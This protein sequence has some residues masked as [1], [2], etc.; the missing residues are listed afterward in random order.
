MCQSFLLVGGTCGRVA[1]FS[2]RDRDCFE[3]RLHGRF[4]GADGVVVETFDDVDVVFPGLGGRRGGAAADAWEANA[5]IASAAAGGTVTRIDIAPSSGPVPLARRGP[6]GTGAAKPVTLEVLVGEE[7][8][9]ALLIESEGVFQ[10]RLPEVPP[11]APPTPSVQRRGR[12]GRRTLRFRIGDAAPVSPAGTRG[13]LGDFVELVGDAI[14]DQVRV[15]VLRFVARAAVTTLRDYLERDLVEGLVDMTR[16][17]PG[18]WKPAPARLAPNWPPDRPGCL[19]LMIHGTFSTTLGSFGAL[20]ATDGGKN[21]LAG[22]GQRYDAILGYDHSTLIADPE[23]NAEAIALALDE[24]EAPTGTTVD[25]VAYS[26]GGLVARTLAEGLM[27]KRLPRLKIGRVA[28]VGCTNGGTALAEPENWKALIDLTTNLAAVAGR[29]LNFSGQPLAGTILRESVKTIGGLVQAIVDE[30]LDRDEVAGLAAMRPNSALIARLDAPATESANPPSYYA[31]GSHF[32]PKL[33][34]A[35]GGVEPPRGI[36]TKLALTLANFAANGIMNEAN[37]L[38]VDN[39]AVKRFGAH[40]GRLK[41]TELWSDNIVVFH[42]NYFQQAEI[43]QA[44]HGFLLVD[45]PSAAPIAKANLPVFKAEDG[46]ASALTRRAEIETSP[47]VVIERAM[48]SETRFY[49]RVA[50]AVLTMIDKAAPEAS[51]LN[52]LD[53]HEPDATPSGEALPETVAAEG[54]VLTSQGVLV[55]VV[56]PLGAVSPRPIG[57]A[58]AGLGGVARPG[59][60]PARGRRGR[61][62]T[63]SH[64]GGRDSELVA[65]QRSAPDVSQPLGAALVGIDCHFM[66]EMAPAPALGR[67]APLSVTISR[68]SLAPAAGTLSAQDHAVVAPEAR[69][70]IEVT[71]AANC[72][73]VAEAKIEAG[74]P[75]VGRPDVYD[76]TI[77]GLA[78]G[79]GEI[80]VDVR[81]GVRRLARLVLQPTFVATERLQASASVASNEPDRPV[82]MMRIYDIAQGQDAFSL[83][84]ELE[85]RDLGFLLQR[86]TETFNFSREDY[87]GG[88]LQETRRCVDRI[89]A[90]SEKLHAATGARGRRSLFR[91]RAAG[92]PSGVVGQPNE[93]RQHRGDIAGAIHTLGD[94]A[95]GRA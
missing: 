17:D 23:Q 51:L 2:P 95:P 61:P 52:A 87:V 21:F 46:V 15:F 22:A 20:G 4:Q 84:F 7:Q 89:R 6:R 78:A 16:P 86:R 70:T 80:W 65:A 27:A 9:A 13:R 39:A 18:A 36:S 69:V 83:L 85:S 45:P 82:V 3:R 76:F 71:A 64:P 81:I 91:Y 60:L 43:V 33:F 67:D 56:P 28:Y 12:A 90:R 26:R 54:Y 53:L 50:S 63:R 55:G 40:A 41:Y 24:I 72:E 49:V 93:H 10:W 58:D 1:F 75:A 92:D 30:G 79:P 42:L 57:A 37:D 94:F 19:L 77:R 68:E 31:V 35:R 44:L 32:Q 29:V 14:F 5:I 59:R 34:S 73:V 38:V 48:G 74:V 8:N 62:P 66:A 11:G 88:D 25:I 47:A